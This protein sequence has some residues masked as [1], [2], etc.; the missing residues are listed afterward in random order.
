MSFKELRKLSETKEQKE[1][2][3]QGFDTRLKAYEK[4]FVEE[5][6]QLA[7]SDKFYSRSYNL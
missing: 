1:K 4:K 7:P 6:K 5:S 2:A 3:A